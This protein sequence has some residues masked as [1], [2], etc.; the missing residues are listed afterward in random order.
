MAKQEQEIKSEN[1]AVEVARALKNTLDKLIPPTV[2][3]RK[4]N[5]DNFMDQLAKFENVNEY[6]DLTDQEKESF[7]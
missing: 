5:K 1:I 7:I 6:H 3:L 4:R 2:D